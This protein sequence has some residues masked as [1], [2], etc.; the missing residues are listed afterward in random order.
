MIRPKD[1]EHDAGIR[2]MFDT[3]TDRGHDPEDVAARMDAADH[4]F[5]LEIFGPAIDRAADWLGLHPFPEEDA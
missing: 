5:W 2:L 1:Y 4:D 3:L